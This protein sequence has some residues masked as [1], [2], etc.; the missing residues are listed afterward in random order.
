MNVPATINGKSLIVYDQERIDLI[1][2]TICKGATDDELM[3]F[4]EQCRRTQLDPVAKQ[5]YAVRRWDNASGR[6]VMSIQ[7]SIDGFR[8]IA[9][10]THQYAGQLGPFWCGD[11]GVWLDAWL[12]SKPPAAAKVGALRHDF[13]EPVWGIARFSSYAQKKGNGQ[14]THMWEKMPDVMLA[15]CAESLALRK[16]FPQDLSGLYTADEMAQAN[17]DLGWQEVALDEKPQIWTDGDAKREAAEQSK[18]AKQARVDEDW[19]KKFFAF[20]DY[21]RQQYDE[22][23][24]KAWMNQKAPEIS[25]FPQPS[26]IKELHDTCASQLQF[27]RSVAASPSAEPDFDPTTGEIAAT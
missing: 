1:K 4:I 11:D 17:P 19:N 20:K 22:A 7:T 10:R 12:S 16:A 6:E 23:A 13:K 3:L 18:I 27:I 2:R 25:V 21:I 26:M 24:L 9:E 14:I 15:K 8:L 5:I